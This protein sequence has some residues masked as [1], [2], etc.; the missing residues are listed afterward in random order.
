MQMYTILY[1][2]ILLKNLKFN[3]AHQKPNF[4]INKKLPD[5]LLVSVFYCQCDKFPQTS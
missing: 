1:D 5:L 4:L 2:Q 3:L